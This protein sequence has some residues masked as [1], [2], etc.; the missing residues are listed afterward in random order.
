[1]DLP[2][3]PQLR[4]SIPRARLWWNWQ[5]RYFEVVVPKGVQVQILLSAP[6]LLLRLPRPRGIGHECAALKSG[7]E[8]TDTEI[9]LAAG[10]RQPRLG[11]FRVRAIRC[12]GGEWR[13]HPHEEQT[14]IER[15]GLLRD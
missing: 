4:Q 2:A 14:Q 10:Q 6:I 15:A 9:W 13:Y 7:I 1:M 8:N 5:T 12:N 11:S 3:V